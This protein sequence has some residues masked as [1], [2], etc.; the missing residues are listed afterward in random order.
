MPQINDFKNKIARNVLG[1][2]NYDALDKGSLP[3]RVNGAVG[4]HMTRAV[5]QMYKMTN[6]Q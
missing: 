1:I 5:W 6:I 2:D 4:G 3:A